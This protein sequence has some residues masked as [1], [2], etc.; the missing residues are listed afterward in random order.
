MIEGRA[1]VAFEEEGRAV[2]AEEPFQM[3]GDLGAVELLREQGGKAIA[4]GEVLN[5]D[6]ER[7]VG[8][9]FGGVAGPGQAGVEPVDAFQGVAMIPPLFLHQG[10][11][12]AA[13]ER[14]GKALVQ[15]A[16][17]A[18]APGGLT[19][20]ILPTMI[21]GNELLI[22]SGVALAVGGWFVAHRYGRMRGFVDANRNGVDD[23]LESAAGVAGA[24][25]HPSKS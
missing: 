4:R 1:V 23:R 25:E 17:A 19:L 10:L 13:R 14:R 11:E 15:R 6:E 2:L 18:I 22:L 8:A 5:G 9:V 16:G 12:L 20:M 3:G 21:A 7:A 24:S